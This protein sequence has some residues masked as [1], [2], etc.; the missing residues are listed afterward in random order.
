MQKEAN[1][2]TNKQIKMEDSYLAHLLL[3]AHTLFAVII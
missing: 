3:T 1:K 2:Q